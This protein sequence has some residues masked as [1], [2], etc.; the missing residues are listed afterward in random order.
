MRD[1][2]KNKL[3]TARSNLPRKALAK[4]IS[5]VIPA[6]NEVESIGELVRE[7]QAVCQIHEYRY[8]II[9]VSDGSTDGTW[10]VILG[11]SAADPRVQGIKF[12]RKFG[13]ACALNAGFQTASFDTVFQM[14]ADLQDDPAEI[15]AFL[16]ALDKGFDLV[17]GYK[18]RRLD[19]LNRVIGSRIYNSL[20][21]A[22][23]GVK[24]HDHNCGF[25][26]Y[27]REIL[28]GLN[29][30]GELHRHIPLIL[31]S[32]GARI[33]EIVIK[34]RPRVFGSSKFGAG[35]IVKGLL[36][37]L[38]VVFLA[39]FRQRPL[40]FLGGLGLLMIMFGLGGLAYLAAIWLG[41]EGIGRRPLL[42]YSSSAL[43]LG[44]QLF[45]TGILAELL[46]FYMM[47]PSHAYVIAERSIISGAGRDWQRREAS[48]FSQHLVPE[49]Q[50]DYPRN[51]PA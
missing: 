13:K 28:S 17:S 49:Y 45:A 8:E 1:E 20:T 16:D 50:S 40:H 43:V 48:D 32:R 18:K 41:G 30:Y 11:L 9:V 14:D 5:I 37:L 36:D 21:S 23:S 26:A 47:R 19:P 34:H 3:T 12:A 33:G 39:L 29:L 27:R 51:P 25:K 4:R 38:T 2:V 10:E 31:S 42:I 6:Y 24:L 15:P 44:F 35:R 7:I 22:V 46:T